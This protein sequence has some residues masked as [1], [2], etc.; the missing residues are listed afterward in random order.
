MVLNSFRVKWIAFLVKKQKKQL[1]VLVGVS[2][3][4]FIASAILLFN[5][6][7]MGAMIPAMSP[8]LFQLGKIILLYGACYSGV[9]LFATLF[10]LPTADAYDRRAEEF[11]SLVDLSQSITG[12][13]EFN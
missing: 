5:S 9:I 1:I 12:M 6:R 8:G 4:I 13:M 3:G 7:A 10:H 11:A 2:L